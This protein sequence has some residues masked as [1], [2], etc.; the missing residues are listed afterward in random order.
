VGTCI[1]EGRELNKEKARFCRFCGNSLLVREPQGKFKDA[2]HSALALERNESITDTWEGGKKEIRQLPEGDVQVLDRGE[3]LLV[4]TDQKLIWLYKMPS[5]EGNQYSAGFRIPLEKISDI[6]FGLRP[7][8]HVAITDDEGVHVVSLFSQRGPN[9]GFDG[10]LQ[11]K[12]YMT[13][14][15]LGLLQGTM[16]KH[17]AE[18]KFTVL[19]LQKKERVQ[20]IV[21]FSFLKDYMEKGG[22]VVQKISCANCGASMRL[23][24]K[25]NTIDCP[26]CKTTHRVQDIFERV[27]Q[28]IG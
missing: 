5:A 12:K 23:P 18:R 7:V 16:M 20:V 14:D 28:L 22:M 9:P 27:R 26:Y 21:D 6:S 25:G 15:E 2:W 10:L 24:E 11:R 4:L 19:E 8:S 3:G 1:C 17:R 13:E